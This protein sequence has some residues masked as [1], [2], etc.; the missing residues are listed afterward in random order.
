MADE[1]VSERDETPKN[2]EL[3]IGAPMGIALPIGIGLGAAM[4]AATDNMATWVGIGAAL[5][6]A[7]GGIGTAVQKNRRKKK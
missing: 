5:G 6:V 4:G 1:S 7:L 2:K 3:P